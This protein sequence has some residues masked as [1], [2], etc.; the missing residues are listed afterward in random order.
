MG[1]LGGGDDEVLLLRT[2]SQELEAELASLREQI[3]RERA[4][5]AAAIDRARLEA[6]T[7]TAR[8]VTHELRNLLSPVAGYGELLARRVPGEDAALADRVKSSA[9]R[10]AD[11]LARLDQIV[12]Y[13]E[14]DFGGE[15]M[16]D[17]DAA[18]SQG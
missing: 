4:R 14:V 11:F 17:L 5:H 8:R 10:A 9:L 7:R 12:R 6:S 2:R 18:T 15:T 1:E 13:R 3:A 16:L